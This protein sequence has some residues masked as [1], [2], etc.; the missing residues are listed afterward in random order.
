MN[1]TIKEI[2]NDFARYYQYLAPSFASIDLAKDIWS[3]WEAS[4][5]TPPDVDGISSKIIDRDKAFFDEIVAVASKNIGSRYNIDYCPFLLQDYNMCARSASDG[6][7]VIIDETFFKA[8]YSLTNILMYGANNLIDNN[9]GGKYS[10]LTKRLIYGIIDREPFVTYNDEN[11]SWVRELLTKDYEIAEFSVFL[12][13]SFKI[14]I[15]A[16][17]ISHHILNH[18][19]G[20]KEKNFNYSGRT[21]TV[22]IDDMDYESE[23]AADIL[24]Y[25]IFM[26]VMNTIDGSLKYAYLLY[27]FEFAPLLL[28][29]IFD[30][31]DKAQKK[32]DGVKMQYTTHPSPD[33][34]KDNLLKTYKIEDPDIL[35]ENLK[36]V[37]NTYMD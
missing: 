33:Q 27:R 2:K 24:G 1:K 15:L 5:V 21:C 31:I 6:Y 9:E 26:S 16:H 3:T 37:L 10:E 11:D 7:L 28:F 13:Q 36:S 14:F 19:T 4:G 23:Y 12:F 20:T 25:K 32:K 8:L 29:D 34:R 17:E 18:T 30:S 35:Y 22:Q